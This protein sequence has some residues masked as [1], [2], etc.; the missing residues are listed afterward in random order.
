LQSNKLAYNDILTPYRNENFRQ[1]AAKERIYTRRTPNSYLLTVNLGMVSGIPIPNF[2]PENG[3]VVSGV[4][5]LAREVR[6]C[7]FDNVK[8]EF[9]GNCLVFK[10]RWDESYEDRW[11]FDAEKIADEAK[12][13]IR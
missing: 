7:L 12:F 9:I 11:Y 3:E 1:Q 6:A 13:L 8:N 2:D 5:I 10:C 4:K